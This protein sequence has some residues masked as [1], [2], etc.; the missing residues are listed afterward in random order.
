MVERPGAAGQKR[1]L[2]RV[3]EGT[4]NPNGQIDLD[5]TLEPSGR[6]LWSGTIDDLTAAALHAADVKADPGTWYKFAQFKA[7]LDGANGTGDDGVFSAVST[8]QPG[9]H[10]PW[11]ATI[12]IAER[13]AALM[14]CR[15]I[16]EHVEQLRPSGDVWIRVE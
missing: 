6:E 2:I 16:V 8:P 10:K 5:E 7:L 3:Q 12:E 4:Y 9:V 15:S 1:M 14:V 11:I 13:S